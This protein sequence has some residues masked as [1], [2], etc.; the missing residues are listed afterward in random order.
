MIE[1]IQND[2]RREIEERKIMIMLKQVDMMTDKWL[3]VLDS[4]AMSISEIA[5]DIEK[6]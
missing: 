2:Y 6:K 5:I 1:G 4:I 3:E